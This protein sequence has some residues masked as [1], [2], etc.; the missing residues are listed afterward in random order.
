MKTC[1]AV[2]CAVYTRKSTDEGLDKEFTSL[3]C[4]RESAQA[5]ILSQQAQGWTCLES[6]YDDGGFTGGNMDRPA[7]KRLLADIALGQID[8]VVVY[9]VDRLSRSL[10]DFARM[11][12]TFEKYQVSFVSV[13]Q[14]F[15]TGS[16]MGR[17]VLNVLLS[18]AQFEREIIAE[19][20]R[21]KIALARRKG[22]WAGGWPL[23]GYDV[24]PRGFK[25]V[26]NQEEAAQVRE[27]FQLYVRLGGL[28]PVVK[29]LARRGW[30]TK[31]WQTRKGHLRGGQPFT[32]TSLHHLL[33]NVVYLG[34]VKH[35][36]EAYPGEHAAIVPLELWQRVHRQL[37]QRGQVRNRCRRQPSAALLSGLLYCRVCGS[38]MTPTHSQKSGGRRY[39]YYACLKALKQGRQSCPSGWVPAGAMEQVVISRLRQLARQETPGGSTGLGLLAEA[40][41]WAELET[42]ERVRV[43]QEIIERVHYDGQRGRLSITLRQAGPSSG[44]ANPKDPCHAYADHD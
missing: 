4:Q 39:G 3:D 36:K 44:T 1:G 14:Q 25:L 11:M 17:L 42:P 2:R 41:A 19:R 24:D 8:C 5:F 32:K 10:L 18:F 35:K 13:T 31:R 16:S 20:T 28:I 26:V 22:Q 30:T 38:A 7:L 29:E 15:H 23:L 37:R 43:L 33:T 12:E 27:I 9:K 6:R 21:D 34:K 40:A